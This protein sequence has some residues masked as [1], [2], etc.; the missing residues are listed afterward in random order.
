[1][2]KMSASL[3]EV[4]RRM[5]LV[6]TVNLCHLLRQTRLREHEVAG[7]ALLLDVDS[8]QIHQLNATATY[9]WRK[10]DQVESREELAGEFVGRFSVEYGKALRAVSETPNS[11]QQL[12]L[13]SPASH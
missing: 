9:I 11:L 6:R 4:A 5:L 3:S 1:M 8:G 2:A 10:C 7:E 13:I 12:N